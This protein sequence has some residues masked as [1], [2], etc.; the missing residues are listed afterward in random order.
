MATMATA[1]R[2]AQATNTAAPI[3]GP[4]SLPIGFQ[5]ATAWLDAAL[6]WQ[7]ASWAANLEAMRLAQQALRPDTWTRLAEQW[8]YALHHSPIPD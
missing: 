2:S 7:T 8:A 5:F 6:A 4:A 1:T 3:H